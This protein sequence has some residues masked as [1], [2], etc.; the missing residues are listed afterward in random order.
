MLDFPLILQV[1]LCVANGMRPH[2]NKFAAGVENRAID[3]SKINGS[4]EPS[5]QS[6]V[7]NGVLLT[8]EN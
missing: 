7:L 3:G 4:P 6:T 5:V 1:K 8:I 2:I